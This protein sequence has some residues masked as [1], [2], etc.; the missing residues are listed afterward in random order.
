EALLE[1]VPEHPAARQ[2]RT[3]AWQQIAA[4]GP[5]AAWPNRGAR[6]P[7][8]GPV[9]APAPFE[10]APRP[11]PENGHG[12]G[13]EAAPIVWINAAA[14]RKGAGPVPAPGRPLAR[15]GEK[16]PGGRF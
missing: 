1:T 14:N 8:A 2:A 3:R 10:P 4:I 9:P 11:E 12:H 16:A 5:S 6:V 13:H 7:Q 15:A